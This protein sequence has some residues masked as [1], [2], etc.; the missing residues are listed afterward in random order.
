MVR[1]EW[2]LGGQP[3]GALWPW[4]FSA[5]SV[6]QQASGQVSSG[7]FAGCY[8]FRKWGKGDTGSV[9][10]YFLKLPVNLQLSQELRDRE[11]EEKRDNC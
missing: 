9:Y 2:T 10:Y 3:N 6:S 1:G 7:D 4:K 5:L 8:H 11:W